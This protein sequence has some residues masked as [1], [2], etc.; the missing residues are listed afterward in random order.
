VALFGL[1]LCF[2]STSARADTVAQVKKSLQVSYNKAASAFGHKDADGAMAMYDPDCTI[3]TTTG[4]S[5]DLLAVRDV[6]E[7]MIDVFQ[8]TSETTHIT[9][10]T[11]ENHDGVESA[12]VMV[13]DVK[14]AVIFS[15]Q[16]KR[17][18]LKDVITRRD[19][20]EK[21][22][23]G[24]KIKQSRVLSD[25]GSVNGKRVKTVDPSDFQ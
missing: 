17:F 14:N 6:L 21:T 15:P 7:K 12:K 3:Y 1:S 25:I 8:K 24:W 9:K 19:Y 23:D 11:V 22:D 4:E 20:W 13:S 5:A 18:N 10:C 16:G 2:L